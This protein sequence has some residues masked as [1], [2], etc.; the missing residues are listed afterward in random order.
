MMTKKAYYIRPAAR[1]YTIS[2]PALLN[3]SMG[4]GNGT[5]SAEDADAR[6]GGGIDFSEDEDDGWE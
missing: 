3:E 5:K 1:V 2:T 6:I 4:F